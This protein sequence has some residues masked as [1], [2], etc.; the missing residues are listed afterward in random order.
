MESKNTLFNQTDL[1]TFNVRGVT[2]G[3]IV[4][5]SLLTSVKDSGLEAMFSGR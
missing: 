1:I 5:V 3:F 4:H 2:D